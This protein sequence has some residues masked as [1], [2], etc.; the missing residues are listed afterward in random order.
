MYLRGSK[1]QT[2]GQARGRAV[3][4]GLRST[5]I[6]LLA[7]QSRGQQHS[8]QDTERIGRVIRAGPI[9]VRIRARAGHTRQTQNKKRSPWAFSLLSVGFDGQMDLAT[10]YI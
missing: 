5:G 3:V 1:R 10:C 2:P 7:G 9:Q 6:S 4:L 8:R